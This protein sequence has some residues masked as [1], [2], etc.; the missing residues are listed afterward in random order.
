MGI[1]AVAV[2]LLVLVAALYAALLN[3]TLVR[4]RNR[5]DNSWALLAVHR[6][7]RR[8]L[9]PG[10][11]A[12]AA[13]AEGTTTLAPGT[14]EAVV[15]ASRAAADAVAPA[16]AGAA[17]DILGEALGRLVEGATA[18]SELPESARFR[19]LRGQLIDAE[20]KIAISCRTYN[21]AVQAY[22]RT[23]LAMPASLIA[24]ALGFSARDP[25]VL[26]N[27]PLTEV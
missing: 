11:L 21:E 13:A 24:G 5:V 22:N 16:E 18:D 1:V 23:L 12:A 17:E 15:N 3:N 25:I 14:P 20:D 26:T 10:L 2:V 8:E 27:A 4:K 9:V 19:E 7:H 6:Q